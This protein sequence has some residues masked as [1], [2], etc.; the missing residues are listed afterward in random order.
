MNPRQAWMALPRRTRLEAVDRA[1]QGRAHSAAGVRLA[2]MAWGRYA[3]RLIVMRVS[4]GLVVAFAVFLVPLAND[5]PFPVAVL[6]LLPMVA[7]MVGEAYAQRRWEGWHRML[8][9]VN[10]RRVLLDQAG[11]A[12]PL[13]VGRSFAAR[14]AVPGYLLLAVVGPAAI[15][16]TGGHFGAA[17]LLAAAAAGLAWRAYRRY[18]RLAQPPLRIDGSGVTFHR[19]GWTIPWSAI[20]SCDLTDEGDRTVSRQ[21]GEK[22]TGVAWKLRRK[23]LEATLATIPEPVRK[24]VTVWLENNDYA[25]VL[26]SGQLAKPPERVAAASRLYL[27]RSGGG[28]ERIGRS[29]SR[30]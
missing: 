12:Q 7:V 20:A 14:Y 5:W 22:S 28:A 30:R 1:K 25:V 29:R 21:Y 17:V 2:A 8:G 6:G 27:E 24:T 16:L 3:P 15:E 13:E 10:G 18:R 19:L 23:R 4:I 9:P 26:D 11:T